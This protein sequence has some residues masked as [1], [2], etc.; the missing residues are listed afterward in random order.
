MDN[1][2]IRVPLLLIGIFFLT[3]FILGYL[4]LTTEDD[5]GTL[6]DGVPEPITTI[7]PDPQQQIVPIIGVLTKT[8]TVLST[9]NFL[10]DTDV[11]LLDEIAMTYKISEESGPGGIIY[12]IFYFQDDSIT[13]SLLDEDLG[14]ARSRA[15]VVLQNKLG[16]NKLEMCAL[17]INVTTP[18]SVSGEYSGKNLG[19][20]FCPDSVFL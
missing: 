4:F 9:R 19:L 13:V 8:G 15:E 20:S 2:S 5:P 17:I 14:F 3:M 6:I 10:D 16:L 18:R 1:S 7:D 11:E 12:Q